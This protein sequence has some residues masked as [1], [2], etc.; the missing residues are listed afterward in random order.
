MTSTAP[1]PDEAASLLRE[2][3]EGFIAARDALVAR[4]RASGRDDDAAVV[5]ALRKPTVVAWALNQL[6]IRDPD[7]VRG[8]LDSG[9]EVRAAQQAA[10]VE[11]GGD[12][13]APEGGGRA[14][15]G[16]ARAHEDR[17]GGP[18]GGRAGLADPCRRDR[19]RLGSVL[20]RP[21]RG[22]GAVRRHL[23]RPP[24]TGGGFGDVFGLTSLEGVARTS[25]RRDRSGASPGPRG[26]A[27]PGARERQRQSGEQEP[28]CGPRW[29]G[30]A[31]IATR[32]HVARGRREGLR[33]GSRTSSR[34]CAGDSRWSSASTRTRRRR[35]PPVSWSSPAPSG[36]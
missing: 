21:R 3:P 1:I 10:V 7:G 20:G 9:A 19:R 26:V 24:S 4:L 15:G 13:P 17:D 27:R 28:S 18:H 25:P 8:L 16:G 34:A 33:T 12:R 23:E 6:S 29:P 32:S 30:S 2:A 22:R 14:Q 36:I 5:K 11:T 35:P 31:A